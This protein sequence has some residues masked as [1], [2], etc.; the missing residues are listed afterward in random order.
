ME[1]TDV[2]QPRENIPKQA[3]T[4]FKQRELI[5]AAGL[6]L[7]CAIVYWPLLRAGY[8]WDDDGWLTNN[9]FIRDWSGLWYIWF[10]PRASIQYYPLVFTAFL[11]QFKLWGLNSVG[12]HLVNIILQAINSILLWRVFRSLGLKSAWVAAAIWAIHPIQVETVGWVAEQKNLLSAAL[13]FSAALLWIKWTGLGMTGKMPV[14]LNMSQNPG[15]GRGYVKINRHWKL[16]L[17]ATIL[18]VLALLAKT[19]ICTLPAALLLVAW[20]KRG[21]VTLVEVLSVIPWFLFGALL[22]C[23][24][25]YIEHGTAGAHGETFNFSLSQRIIIAGKDL[26]FYPLKL[27]WPHPLLAV[28][29]RWDVEHI[30]PIDWLFPISALMVSIILWLLRKRI[31]RGPLTAVAYYKIMLFPVLGFVSFYTMEYTFVADHYQYLACIGIIALLVESATLLL[32]ELSDRMTNTLFKNA[33]AS[34]SRTWNAGP[35]A[36]V[37]IAVL[38]PLGIM[39]NVQSQLYHPPVNI[40]RHVLDYDPNSWVAL[41]QL[42]AWEAAHEQPDAALATISRAIEAGGGADVYV[43]KN[44]AD[45]LISVKHDYHD[46]IDYLIKSLRADPYQP[47]AISELA[48]CYEQSGDMEKAI[49]SL[50]HGMDYLPNDPLLHRKLGEDLEQLGFSD[51]ALEQFAMA[52][53]TE[54]ND[55]QSIRDQNQLLEK[56]KDVQSGAESKPASNGNGLNFYR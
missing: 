37:S 4:P 13:G 56:M 45:L 5:A 9:P 19:D 11:L 49:Q 16:L 3:K 6:L 7:L 1:F 12:Y 22:A 28:Y 41:E 52:L 26:W 21:R 8:I 40:W 43:T 27:L 48:F 18:F 25:I 35:L 42:G 44:M 24:T 32:P 20:W 54:P 53:Q 33:A 51:E 39:N 34:A 17:P 30:A 36:I 31:G 55:A 46:A 14:P 2:S 23:M 29:P 15:Q 38:M 50:R 47:D 10:F